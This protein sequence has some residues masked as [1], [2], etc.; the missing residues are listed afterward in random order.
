MTELSI[1]IPTFNRAEYLPVMLDSIFKQGI[2]D[3]VEVLV[4]DN[5]SYDDT[6]RIV[7]EYKARYKNLVYSI[8]T[9][10]YDLRFIHL[11]FTIYLVI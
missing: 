10:I 8:I 3:G 7:K 6:A 2:F 11:P 4:S 9:L 1:C 5:N